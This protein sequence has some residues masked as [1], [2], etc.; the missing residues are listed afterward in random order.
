[1]I[2]ETL[3]G[4]AE[5]EYKWRLQMKTFLKCLAVLVAAL[6]LGV[7]SALILM[8]SPLVTTSIKNGAWEVNL[9]IG[10]RKADM[11]TRAAVARMGLFALNKSEAIYFSAHTDDEGMPL[12]AG[13]DYRIEGKYLDA[14]W[15]SITVYGADQFLI[16]NEQNRYAFNGK[17]VQR[18]T[19]G[20]YI[21]HLSAAPKEKNWLPSGNEKQLYVLLR[22]YNPEASVYENPGDIQL[23]RIV[24]EE[25]R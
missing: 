1:M 15:W 23:P 12:Q 13:C 18:E 8:K 4:E 16:P 17:T 3:Y 9:A 10:S 19:D 14:R 22:L 25:C 5:D 7:G 2:Y 20:S 6:I 24:K 21:I 11:Y